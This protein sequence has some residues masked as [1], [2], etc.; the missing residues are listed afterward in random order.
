MDLQAL[1]FTAIAAFAIGLLLGP[2]AIP[3]LH[4]LKF[5]QSIREEGP[6]HHQVKAGTPTMGG[7]IILI[8]VVLTTLRFAFDNLDTAMLLV[9]TVGFGLI[10]FADDLIKILK[11]RNLGLTAKQKI[12]LQS[13]L[14]ILLFLMLYLQQGRSEGFAI[15]IPFSNWALSIGVLYIVF[16]LLVLVGTT[17]AVNLTDGLDG[18][19]SGSAIMVFAAYAIYAYWHTNYDVALFC[20]AMVGA[21]AAFL[22]FNRHPAKVFMGDTGSL[23]IGGG[24]A[25]VAVLTHSELALILFGLVFV[26]EALSVMI[27]VFSYRTFGRRVFRMSPLHHHFELGGWSEWEVVLLFWFASFICAFGTLALLSY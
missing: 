14:T 8:A 16:L 3:I 5:G 10:G 17:N 6:Q 22:A 7:V 11:K 27:Q 1:L 4:R 26:I 2:I 18:L 20:A 13:L 15:H 24:L 25:M 23:A 12:V 19:L 9:A 21:L